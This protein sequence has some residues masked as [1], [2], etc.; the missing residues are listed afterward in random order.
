MVTNIYGNLQRCPECGTVCW[1]EYWKVIDDEE[2]CP[3][4]GWHGVALPMDVYNKNGMIIYME[5]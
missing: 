2:E 3:L 4:C 5:R 1:E